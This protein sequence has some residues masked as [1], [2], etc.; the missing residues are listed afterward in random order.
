MKTYIAID[1]KSF[2]ASVECVERGLDPLT[3]NLVVADASRSSKTICLAVSPA[4][5]AYGLK[6]RCR[7]FEVEQKIKELKYQKGL[8]V[9]Y[10]TAIPHMALYMEY[11]ARIYQIYTKYVSEQDI[12]VYSIDEVFMDVSEYLS[13]Y[14]MSAYELCQTIIQ[15]VLQT[16]GITATAG[17][18]PNLYLCKVAMDIVAKKQKA[19]PYG[20]RIAQIDEMSYRKLLWEHTPLTDFWR[21]G[22]GIS[23]RLEDH[24]LYTMGDI[25]RESLLD[26][27]WF[28]DEFGI[29][30]EILIDHA[31]GYEPCTIENIKQY[32]P[33]LSSISSGQVLSKPYKKD[34]A[35]II[36]R[37]MVEGLIHDLIDKQ[38]VTSGISLYIGYDRIN[39][40][41]NSYRGEVKKDY[42]GRMTPKSANK[43]IQLK[44]HTSSYNKLVSQ[45]MYL[46]DKI[47]NPKLSVRRINI[48]FHNCI[49]EKE[50]FEQLDLFSNPEKET[51]DKQ[52]QQT[53]LNIEKKFGKG[54]VFK[55]TDLEEGATTLE[56]QKQI[57]GHRA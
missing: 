37:E 48:A 10:I 39:L 1:L 8:D 23:K 17:I 49:P 7:L 16:T 18:A 55:G 44:S 42:F 34:Q 28:Y 43:S 11:S 27:E 41:S 2:Y 47:M 14:K 5:K 45:T 52:L 46:F 3:A 32:K 51:K 26:E 40:N 4:L 22:R 21:V 54:S 30:A 33:N 25:A 56:R 35:R 12:H 31:W 6:G 13:L 19:D 50:S 20:V 15:D 29:D 53:L 57:G 9:K 36:V 24:G 38:L